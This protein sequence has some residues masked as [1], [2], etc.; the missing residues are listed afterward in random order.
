MKL[1]NNNDIFN[2]EKNIDR[3]SDKNNKNNIIY[4][5]KI[6]LLPYY[7]KKRT[8]KK[9]NKELDSQNLGKSCEINNN[10]FF[11]NS[12]ELYNTDSTQDNN[13][14]NHS[15]NDKIFK[16]KISKY[17]KRQNNI[18][19]PQTFKMN[20]LNLTRN[21]LN[22]K[23]YNNSIKTIS[24]FKN[25]I[26]KNNFNF[27]INNVNKNHKNFNIIQQNNYINNSF[28][29]NLLNNKNLSKNKD[30][31][32]NISDNSKIY[33]T[34]RIK[35]PYLNIFQKKMITISIQIIENHFLKHKKYKI[36][37]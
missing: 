2:K 14:I 21:S 26:E 19:T 4:K 13:N 7:S 31:S 25:Y 10:I 20:H 8:Y 9:I 34:D 15:N 32:Y 18:N 11:R 33:R 30:V 1:E 5:P 22:N 16:K 12:N 3:N 35:R 23:T 36:L 24:P 29:Y 37:N 27:Y 17:S 28:E 6:E